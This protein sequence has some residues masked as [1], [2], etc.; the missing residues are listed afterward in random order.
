MKII[1]WNVNGIRSIQ[2]KGFLEF[3]GSCQADVICLQETKAH[4]EQ[5]PPE[6]AA[7]RNWHVHWSSATRK[8]YS[9]VATFS[10]AL[11]KQVRLG[12]DWPE[13]DQEGRF[14]I[15]TFDAFT[16]YNIY[17]PNGGSGPERHL[18]KLKFLEQLYGHLSERLARGE[19]IIVVGDYNVAHTALD[20]YDPV[21]L[22]SVSGF[23]PE[24][25]EWFEKFID[26][27]FVDTFRHFYPDRDQI[28]SWWSYRERSRIGN[29]GWRIDYI[30][31]S[32]N[33]RPSLR[34]AA[35]LD[36]VHGSDHC[37]VSVDLEL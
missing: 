29:R 36:E 28:Y 7:P 19:R 12:L 16:L 26:L 34:S 21:K 20:V 3:L 35:V 22:S 25:R 4:P 9:G 23:L 17:F 15:T 24:E 30:C 13:F 1:S 2:K 27:G 8:G 11:P 5:L 6:L 33:L 18:F 14:V 31:I 37:P 32:E 10:R